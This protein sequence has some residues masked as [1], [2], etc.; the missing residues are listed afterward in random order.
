MHCREFVKVREREQSKSALVE[1][2]S[3]MVIKKRD[4]FIE[5]TKKG[6]MIVIRRVLCIESSMI[7]RV[8]D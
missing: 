8:T 6:P 7:L 1:N 4:N 3:F 2:S 5:Q